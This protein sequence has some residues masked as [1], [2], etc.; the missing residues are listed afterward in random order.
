MRFFWCITL[1]LHELRTRGMQ[2]EQPRPITVYYDGVAVGEY[3]ADLLADGKE[4]VELK[5][6]EAISDAHQAQLLNYLKATG[7]EV[8]LVLNFGPEAA[9]KRIIFTKNYKKKSA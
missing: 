7:T 9:F 2:V 5:V 1:L 4:I 6:A 3:F 8:G